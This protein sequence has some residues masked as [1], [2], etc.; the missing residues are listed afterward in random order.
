MRQIAIRGLC[1]GHQVN[2]REFIPAPAS[3]ISSCLFAHSCCRSSPTP[4]DSA[5]PFVVGRLPLGRCY[6]PG[7]IYSRQPVVARALVSNGVHHRRRGQRL[8]LRQTELVNCGT[9]FT[10]G[11]NL[12][13]DDRRHSGEIRS[14]GAINKQPSKELATHTLLERRQYHL[15]YST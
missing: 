14:L 6:Q 7:Q 3:G 2:R 10:H 11:A 9:E 1:A 4:E 8:R 15:I 5:C 13:A 12:A